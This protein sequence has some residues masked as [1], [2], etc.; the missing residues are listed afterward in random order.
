MTVQWRFNETGELEVREV[1]EPKFK[2][3]D[4]V[5]LIKKYRIHKGMFVV[6]SI[7]IGSESILYSC[8]GTNDKG[9]VIWFSCGEGAL[10]KA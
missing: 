1:G 4:K 9:Q 8:L 2:V 6:S 3:G 5:R 7:G 10:E